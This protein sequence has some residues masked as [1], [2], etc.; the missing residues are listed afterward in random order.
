MIRINPQNFQKKYKSIV[1]IDRNELNKV[2]VSKI[3]LDSL[4]KDF[5]PIMNSLIS[6][7]FL[8]PTYKY[9][10]FV[11]EYIKLCLFIADAI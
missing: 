4:K 2:D 9:R 1:S 5:Y 7:N 8:D 3:K 6:E 10:D 11:R